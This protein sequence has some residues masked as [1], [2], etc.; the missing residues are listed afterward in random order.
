MQFK[1][2]HPILHIFQFICTPSSL[3]CSR[4]SEIG[5]VTRLRAVRSC[6]QVAAEA[7]GLSVL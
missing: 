3:L 2:G 7:T 1:H 4:G 5:I 6:V